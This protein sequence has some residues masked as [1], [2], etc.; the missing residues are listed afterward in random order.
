MQETLKRPRGVFLHL[1]GSPIILTL[2]QHIL[3]ISL[4]GAFFGGANGI[5]V[6]Q[7]HERL[8]SVGLVLGVPMDGHKSDVGASHVGGDEEG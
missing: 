6:K 4:I 2:D 1:S 8:L 7:V 5:F 3:L